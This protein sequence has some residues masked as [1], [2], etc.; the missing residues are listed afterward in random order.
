MVALLHKDCGD[1]AV[2]GDVG[3]VLAE[4]KDG[5]QYLCLSCLERLTLKNIKR[6]IF[7]QRCEGIKKQLRC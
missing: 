3:F 5:K 2:E 1:I 6:V 7:E 4:I